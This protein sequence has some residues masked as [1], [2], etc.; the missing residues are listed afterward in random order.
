MNNNQHGMTSSDPKSPGNDG[1]IDSFLPHSQWTSNLKKMLPYKGVIERK[2]KTDVQ[3][4]KEGNP[5]VDDDDA[6]NLQSRGTRPFTIVHASETDNI[7]MSNDQ[8][9]N[10]NQS[11]AALSSLHHDD[12]EMIEQVIEELKQTPQNQQIDLDKLKQCLNK[13]RSSMKSKLKSFLA[14]CLQNDETFKQIIQEQTQKT[15]DD[16]Q[17]QDIIEKLSKMTSEA[18]VVET[19]ELRKLPKKRNLKNLKEGANKK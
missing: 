13:K 11:K 1:Q 4:C 15:E 7:E 16:S 10:P 18:D 19:E 9:S 2:N 17:V 5:E 6:G 14:D 3:T 8:S 12:K